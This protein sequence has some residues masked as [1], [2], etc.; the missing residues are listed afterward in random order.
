MGRPVSK[1]PASNNCCFPLASVTFPRAIRQV[2]P[3]IDTDVLGMK[4]DT[5]LL[6]AGAQVYIVDEQT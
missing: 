6:G 1:V 3:E 5:E 2:D 4:N